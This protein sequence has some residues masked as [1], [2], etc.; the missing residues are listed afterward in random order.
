MAL[1]DDCAAIVSTTQTQQRQA[2]ES[3]V[4]F[5]SVVM[6]TMGPVLAFGVPPI[7]E[8]LGYRPSEPIP[9]TYPRASFSPPPSLL[10]SLCHGPGFKIFDV[11]S[12]F[13][14]FEL[15]VPKRQRRPVQGYEDEE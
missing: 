3:P 14:H 2:H 7:R 4:L 8:H 6:G 1:P 9:A 13:F 15:I 11:N 12:L 5:Y 10:P